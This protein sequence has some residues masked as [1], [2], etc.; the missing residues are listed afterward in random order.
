MWPSVPRCR[1]P[2]RKG[3]CRGHEGVRRHD[4]LVPWSDIVQD[5]RRFQRGSTGM[6]DKDP[7]AGEP[8]FN[9]FLAA[10]R[11]R[12]ARGKLSVHHHR[13]SDVIELFAGN[14]RPVKRDFRQIIGHA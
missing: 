10:L 1:P 9:P 11:E 2:Q 8:V 4:D 7:L 12:S 3:A 13:L 6:G 14:K 5:R